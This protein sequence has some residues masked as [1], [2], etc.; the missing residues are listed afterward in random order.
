MKLRIQGDS[1]RLR[2]TRP[3]VD[4]LVEG[5]EVRDAVHVAPG[6]SVGYAVR[7]GERGPLAAAWD[8]TSLVVTV[9]RGDLAGWP[10]DDREGFAAVQDAGGGRRLAIH[11]EKDYACGH[12]EGEHRDAFPRPAAT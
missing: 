12:R 1:L 8:G 3:E 9:P 2:L 4:R 7:V 11:V 6:V 10:E 5:G